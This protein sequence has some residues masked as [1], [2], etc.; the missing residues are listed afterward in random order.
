MLVA[1]C[2]NCVAN[3]CGAYHDECEKYQAF[4]RDNAIANKKRAEETKMFDSFMA[5]IARGNRGKR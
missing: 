2:K 3:P 4:K 1:P 5:S